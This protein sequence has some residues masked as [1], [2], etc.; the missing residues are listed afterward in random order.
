MQTE[1]CDNCKTPAAPNDQGHDG[2]IKVAKFRMHK[3]AHEDLPAPIAALMGDREVPEHLCPT[4]HDFCSD[5]CLTA[6]VANNYEPDVAGVFDHITPEDFAE[7][8]PPDERP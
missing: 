4:Q 2:W 6:F 8:L 7:A 3:G 1:I 5:K